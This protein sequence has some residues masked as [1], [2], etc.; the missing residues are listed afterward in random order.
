M[1][2]SL[3]IISIQKQVEV[4]GKHARRSEEIVEIAGIDPS[5]G[6]VLVNSVFEYD[7]VADVAR[8]SGRSHVLSAIGKLHGLTAE[9][10]NEIVRE[11][12]QVL[13]AMQKQKITSYAPV[14]KIIYVYYVNRKLVMK[15]IDNLSV[16]LA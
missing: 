7:P 5:T 10:V 16:F 12:E 3:D 1:L 2:Q 15:N 13:L 4:N 11:R 6:N 9:Q 8:F 14:S